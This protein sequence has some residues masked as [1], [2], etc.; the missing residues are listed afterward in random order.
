M[1]RPI[2]IA[3]SGGVDSLAACCLLLKTG[4]S[5]AGVYFIT[6]YESAGTDSQAS[7]ELRE[8][9]QRLGIP[10]HLIDLKKE[11]KSR[12]VDPF[13]DSYFKGE[14][15]NPCMVCNPA[16]K[17]GVMMDF[18]VKDLGARSLAT[19]HYARVK[20]GADGRIHLYKGA[21]LKKDQSYFLGFLKQNQLA[22]CLFPLGDL[23]KDM[24]RE[25]VR[26]HGLTDLAAHESQE[27]CFIKDEKYWEFIKKQPRFQDA[28]GDI[29]DVQG[30]VIGEHHGIFAFTIGQRRGINVPAKEAYYVKKII[31]SENSIVVG[32]KNDLMSAKATVRDV[33]WIIEAPSGE[34]RVR[35]RLRYRHKEAWSTLK[36]LSQGAEIVF[37]EPQSAITPGQG[38]VFYDDDRVVGAGWI[39]KGY[40]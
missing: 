11:F 24:A 3:V 15:P 25:I 1:S 34:I 14:T 31:P 27:A 7:P 40:E 16:I 17:F 2:A 30:N 5:L 35:T 21:D 36:P 4:A 23:T 18:A 37:D 10:L 20:E 38:A 9:A 8:A 39:T 12:V 19:G 29:L 28:P 22:S 26:D 13:V 6:G 32:S 33:N